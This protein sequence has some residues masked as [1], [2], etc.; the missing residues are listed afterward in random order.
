MLNVVK[1]NSALREGYQLDEAQSVAGPLPMHELL[2]PTEGGR[3]SY[4]SAGSVPARG[5]VA[6]HEAGARE[7]ARLPRLHANERKGVRLC[8][9]EMG[10]LYSRL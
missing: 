7:I 5:D 10:K 9:S 3:D 4:C 8:Q 1:G 2:A 6:V